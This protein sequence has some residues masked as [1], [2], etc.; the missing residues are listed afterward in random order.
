MAK[1]KLLFSTPAEGV[2]IRTG[3]SRVLTRKDRH[4][5]HHHHHKD[6]GIEVKKYETIRL[7]AEN[8]GTSA[9][10]VTVAMTSTQNGRSNNYR[11]ARV[12]LAPG[13]SYTDTYRVPGRY[14]NI[15]AYSTGYSGD[16]GGRGRGRI[17]TIDVQLYGR[18]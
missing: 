2:S 5:H 16:C 13:Q 1:N 11:L 17:D 7:F 15:T 8:R 4:H 18:K 3:S 6:R 12:R 9:T 10:S 14:V